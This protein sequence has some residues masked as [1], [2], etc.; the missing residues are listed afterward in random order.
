MNSKYAAFVIL[1]IFVAAFG[2]VFGPKL[3]KDESPAVKEPLDLE[4]DVNLPAGE[5]TPVLEDK[6]ELP[7][8]SSRYPVP[9]LNRPV[10]IYS[11]LPEETKKLAKD[12]ISA[13]TD[14]LENSAVLVSEWIELGNYRK[15]IGDY[16]AAIEIWRY[17]SG[18]NPENHVLLNNIANLY[19]G[20]LRD[21]QKAEEYYLKAINA[22]PN[23]PYPY[24]AAFEFYKSVLKDNK[25][26]EDIVRKGI[27]AVPSARAEL[28][29][30]LD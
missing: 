27:A 5:T 24:F 1:F 16:D 17:A 25:K 19:S 9:D 30:L 4:Y 7:V 18:L 23:L 10:I 2:F 28:E 20:Y 15:L 8:T 26:A 6:K 21:Y 29:A 13:I 3:V 14:I 11:E 12:R 22:A